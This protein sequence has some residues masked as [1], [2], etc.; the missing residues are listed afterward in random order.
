[1]SS[2]VNRNLDESIHH[3]FFRPIAIPIWL[4]KLSSLNIKL[5][6][7]TEKAK[8]GREQKETRRQKIFKQASYYNISEVSQTLQ[9]VVSVY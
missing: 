4:S 7:K 8:V 6:G 1:M 2:R 3:P 9:L 5:E